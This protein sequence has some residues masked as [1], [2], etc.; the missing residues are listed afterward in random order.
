HFP[1]YGLYFPVSPD[2]DVWPDLL[3]IEHGRAREEALSV[4]L[5]DQRL[6]I[7]AK[8]GFHTFYYFAINDGYP[9]QVERRW[10][11]AIAAWP[12]RVALSGWRG[13]GIEYREMNADTS[14][15]F[16]RD[17]VRQADGIVERIGPLAGIFFDTVHH[18]DLDFAHDDG[19]TLV[20]DR[21]RPKRAYSINF[22]YDFFLEHLA[23]RLHHRR[24]F[25]F[26]NGPA[27]IRNARGVDAVML[28]GEGG[29]EWEYEFEYRRFLVCLA[30]PL[31]W[32][33]P[34]RPH[35]RR[36]VLLQRCLL[37]GGRPSAPS[38]AYADFDGSWSADVDRALWLPYLPLYARLSGRRLCFEPDPLDV[39]TG[40]RGELFTL[41]DGRYALALI[42]ESLSVFDPAN[43]REA[44]VSLR[45]KNPVSQAMVFT[46]LDH[47]GSPLELSHDPAGGVGIELKDFRGTALVLIGE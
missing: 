9:P 33:F 22:C 28:E 34:G 35:Q 15:T 6:G 21:D 46:P 47:A 24:Q 23:R 45:L 17:L 41:P 29:R 44:K 8:A 2:T 7:L 11:D 36:E 26:I 19:L 10:P 4:K 13:G 1:W 31:V 18:S 20:Y 3:Q 38:S 27:A 43:R 30:R 5:I 25:L 42:D 14:Y 40:C 37:Y 16:G 32:L 39:P 12:D